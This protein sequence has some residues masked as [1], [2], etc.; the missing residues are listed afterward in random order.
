MICTSLICAWIAA[1]KAELKSR[2]LP[3]EHLCRARSRT[4]RSRI[5]DVVELQ[6]E[7]FAVETRTD[8]RLESCRQHARIRVVHRTDDLI[9]FANRDRE[10]PRLEQYFGDRDSSGTGTP[11]TGPRSCNAALRRRCRRPRPPSV[12]RF[13]A[14]RTST[15]WVLRFVQLT[16]FAVG[17][18]GGVAGSVAN[19]RRLATRNLSREQRPLARGNH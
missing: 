6:N 15:R 13:W 2:T 18:G 1:G 3:G 5:A 19:L 14:L 4:G 7:E 12:R 11:P 9:A 8:L 16:P 17:G 10:E